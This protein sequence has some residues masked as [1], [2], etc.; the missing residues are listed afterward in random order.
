M[1]NINNHVILWDEGIGLSLTKDV[2]GADTIVTPDLLEGALR[3]LRLLSPTELLMG[4]EDTSN[5]RRGGA[6]TYIASGQITFSLRSKLNIRRFVAKA[7]VTFPL[8]PERALDQWVERFTLLSTLGVPCPEIY[9]AHKGVLYQEFVP[10]D[11]L[12]CWK[13]ASISNQRE[14][15]LQLVEMAAV[16]DACG[17][18]PIS[19]L[20]DVLLRGGVIYLVD[21]G[22][23][24]GTWDFLNSSETSRMSLEQSSFVTPTYLGEL[25]TRYE[26][27]FARARTSIASREIRTI[28]GGA[29]ETFHV[30]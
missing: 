8:Q 18:K 20:N 29:I 27:R 15:L 4:Y 25:Q 16:L 26:S 10:D 6:E 30:K 3:K 22:S 24:L 1:A 17:F 23:D 19:F 5:W 14:L 11:L 21:A 2:I 28:L 12:T 13:K 7:A 9:S